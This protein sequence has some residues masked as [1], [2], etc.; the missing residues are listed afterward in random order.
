MADI[1]PPAVQRPALLKLAEALGCRDNAL[2]RDECGDWAIFG[3]H[4]HIYAIPGTLDRPKTPGFQIFVLSE[5]MRTGAV[6]RWTKQGWTYAKQALG[7]A[8]LTNDGGLEGA[9]FI[10]RLPTPA[11]ADA[12]RRYVGIAKKREVSDEERARLSGMGHRFEK[13]PDCEEGALGPPA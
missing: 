4:G 13:R 5:N 6:D 12:I 1:Y 8:G 3:R 11:E 2:R 9:F 10:D 7:F